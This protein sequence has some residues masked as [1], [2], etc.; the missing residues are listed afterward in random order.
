MLASCSLVLSLQQCFDH[1]RVEEV[2]LLDVKLVIGLVV[3]ASSQLGLLSAR[4]ILGLET[5]ETVWLG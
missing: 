5:D 3:E 1:K 2:G 4:A